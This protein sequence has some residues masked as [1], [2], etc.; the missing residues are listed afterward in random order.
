MVARTSGMIRADAV[1][2]LPAGEYWIGDDAIPTCA[3][4]HLRKFRVDVWIESRFAPWGAFEEFVT[5][6]GYA[7]QRLWRAADGESFPASGVP[8]SVDDRCESIREATF[9]GMPPAWRENEPGPLMPLLGTTWFEAMAIC[10]FFGG[11]LPFE[12][13]W[14]ASVTAK[15]M[16]PRRERSGMFQE[17]TG[18]AFFSRYWRADA[19]VR[20][21]AWAVGSE[22]VV[23]GYS[24]GEPAFATAARRC[25]EPA[26]G[27]RFRGF[28]RV[29]DRD[30][31]ARASCGGSSQ[32]S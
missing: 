10:R 5:A 32:A 11:R 14:E 4:R 16:Q 3:P 15:V 13:E 20:G 19:A 22:V 1:R 9:A 8:G 26:S 23:R 24:I 21:K 12:A 2:T 6:G 30:P 7:D 29:W 28:R 25:A 17:W 27:G 31:V 18:D